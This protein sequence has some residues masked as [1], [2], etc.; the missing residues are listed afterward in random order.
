MKRTP[1]YELH[2][3]YG[4]KMV[5]F[6]GW[7]MPV[8]YTAGIIEEH[9]RTRNAAGLFDVSHMGEILIEGPDACDFMQMLISNDIKRAVTGQ[10]VYSLMCFPDGG[11]VD[12]LLVYKMSEEKYL[13]VVNA[14][15]TET[16]FE[17]ICRQKNDDWRGEERMEAR[18]GG[19]RIDNVSSQYAQLA[20]QGPKAA[21]ILQKLTIE[22]LNDI[23]FFHFDPLLGIGG[24]D[25][26][27]SRTGYTGEDGFEVYVEP[28]SA[29][30]LWEQIMVAGEEY[31]LLPVGLGA[32]DTLRLE[33][34]LPLYGHELS[35]GITP[36]EAGLHKFVKFNK[37]I[38][39][40]K[41]SNYANYA[42]YANYDRHGGFI[43]EESLFNATS[44]SSIQ[45]NLMGKFEG[46]EFP[47]S[48]EYIKNK[49]L[50]LRYLVGF[51]MLGNGLARNNYEV[52]KN[53]RQIG[54]VTSG[55]YSPTLKKNIGMALIGYNATEDKA[56]PSKI[57]DG[58]IIIIKIRNKEVEALVVSLPFYRKKYKKYD[59]GGEK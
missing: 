43:G 13:L 51:E 22:N 10:V 31:G 58:D 57:E 24:S 15:N 29:E 8:Q 18:W 44:I 28:E 1:L 14:A 2:L 3:K 52:F 33:A 5:P 49:E 53:G 54:F 19:V 48:S 9:N 30:E 46:Q 38:N 25:V 56:V 50:S 21:D 59:V 35:A 39:Y 45:K 17:W 20:I 6:G 27:I 55:S 40:G 41:Y 26:L 16:D 23:A 12:D 34:A 47:K 32:R 42:N 7:E 4:A 11:T 37:Y 36:L